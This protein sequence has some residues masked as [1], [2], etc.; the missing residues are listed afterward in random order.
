MERENYIEAVAQR[1][2]IGF[3]NLRKLVYAYA[4]RTGLAAPAVR[5]KSG[6][7]KKPD[8]RDTKKK[9]QRLLLTWLVEEPSVYPKIKK[10][11]SPRDFTEDLYKKIAEKLFQGLEEGH[12][13][14]AALVGLF[15]DEEEQREVMKGLGTSL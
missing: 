1:Y 8:G 10:Y 11:I 3:E 15:E 5:P 4:A 9:P 14:P 12:V 6:I 13:E 2:H 7:Q